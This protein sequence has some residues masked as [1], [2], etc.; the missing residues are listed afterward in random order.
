MVD[1]KSSEDTVSRNSFAGS[2]LRSHFNSTI[3]GDSASQAE[4]FVSAYKEN[5]GLAASPRDV[6]CAS[7]VH[8]VAR[9]DIQ[10]ASFSDRKSS[11]GVKT[12][13]VNCLSMIRESAELDVLETSGVNQSPVVQEL[14]L[15]RHSL[16]QHTTE[17]DSPA[18]SNK[19]VLKM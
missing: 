5:A 16:Q 7:V 10:T 8:E 3:G 12:A 19:S 9:E 4:S 1:D 2:H 13:S 6:Y 15:P 17:D 11:V 14:R 18:A